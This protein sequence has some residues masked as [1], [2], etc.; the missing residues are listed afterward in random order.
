M[1]KDAGFEPVFII[2]AA[3]SGTKMLRDLIAFT[4]NID[5]VP[6]DV[7]YIWRMGNENVP[8]DEL[9]PEMACSEARA[10]IID[11]L[12][13]Y[14]RN[15]KFLLEKTVSNSL[16]VPFVD[17]VFP[18]AK[19]IHLVRDGLD[20]TESAYR[21]WL[22]PP[23]WEYIFEKLKTFPISSAFKYG[24]S[25][26]RKTLNRVLPI[27]RNRA[28]TTW[29]PLYNGIQD[30][31][32]TYSL[33]EVCALQWYW[34][35][36]KASDALGRLPAERVLNVRYEAFVREPR[37]GLEAIVNFIDPGIDLSPG[38]LNGQVTDK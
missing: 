23:D 8:H 38:R 3:R 4:A 28:F 19:Y 18:G 29:G 25:Y 2:G 30:D 26:A 13:R 12:K 32:Q 36:K 35:V 24:V 11:K 17:H 14:S 27:Q 16:R 9:A 15:G 20:V 5:K 37:A 21:Q 33:I 10:R 6:F 31:L 34:S 1:K 22:A 7:N